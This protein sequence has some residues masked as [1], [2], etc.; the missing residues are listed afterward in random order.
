MRVMV[1]NGP[2]LNFLGIREPGIYGEKS[3]DSICAFIHESASKYGIQ[4]DIL[5]SNVEGEIVNYLQ[6]AYM[7][8]YDGIVINPAAYSH[9]SIAIYDAIKA[10]GIPAVEVHLSNIHKREEFRHKSVTAP[11]CI[12]SICGF[13]HYGYAMALEAIKVMNDRV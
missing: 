12:G 10:S 7:D 11:A 9:Y 2:N 13:G 3:Y 5:Q 6:K 1:I 8:K 4:A